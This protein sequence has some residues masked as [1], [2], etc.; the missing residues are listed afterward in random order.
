MYG[1]IDKIQQDPFIKVLKGLILFFMERC[2]LTLPKPKQSNKHFVVS[3]SEPLGPLRANLR[4]GRVEG[5]TG[6]KTWDT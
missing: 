5:E 2:I 1:N 3:L 4:P 6:R